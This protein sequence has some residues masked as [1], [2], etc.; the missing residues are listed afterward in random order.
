MYNTAEFIVERNAAW[1]NVLK[2]DTLSTTGHQAY[3]DL[4]TKNK[5]TFYWRCPQNEGT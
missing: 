4:K 5:M 2:S 1:R 3:G